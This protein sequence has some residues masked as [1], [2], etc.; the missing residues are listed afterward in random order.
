[1]WWLLLVFS[2]FALANEEKAEDVKPCRQNCTMVGN[3]TK[4]ECVYYANNEDW[5]PTAYAK[6]ASCACKGVPGT[7][8]FFFLFWLL[9]FVLSFPFCLHSILLPCP[10]M[11]PSFF[12]FFS[13]MVKQLK[14]YFVIFCFFFFSGLF[15]GVLFSFYWQRAFLGLFS[16]GWASPSAACVRAHLIHS[17]K[18]VNDTLKQQMKAMKQKWC[19]DVCFEV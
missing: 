2:T 18:I 10:L 8:L 3:A 6:S 1:M 7:K 16:Q 4:D 13:L 14:I 9:F 5:L 15:V 11:D 17:H 12:G 19:N